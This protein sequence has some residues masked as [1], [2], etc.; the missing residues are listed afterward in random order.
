MRA[1][2]RTPAISALSIMTPALSQHSGLVAA[3]ARPSPPNYASVRNISPAVLNLQ[4]VYEQNRQRLQKK[5]VAGVPDI[6]TTQQTK[7][8]P[9]LLLMGQR[10]C[11]LAPLWKLDRSPPSLGLR[12]PWVPLTDAT[13]AASR[14]SRASCSTS[15]LRA[16]PSSSSPPP[17]SRRIVSS[18]WDGLGVLLAFCHG[19]LTSSQLLHGRPNLGL[20]GADRGL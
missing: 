17:G 15:W 14:P 18:A 2:T 1:L 7:G 10:R 19:E 11:A 13:G 8:T 20:P 6:T 9:R 16:R 4:R 12:V 3:D 5:D